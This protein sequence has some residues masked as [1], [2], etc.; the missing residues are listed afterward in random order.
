MT[1]CGSILYSF[2]GQAMVLPL[3]NKLKHPPGMVGVFGVLSVGMSLVSSVYAA[4][5]F[6]GYITY[7]ADVKGSITLNLPQQAAFTAVK[8][9]LTLVVYFGF[10]IQQ[11][12]IFDFLNFVQQMIKIWL[13]DNCHCGS[14]FGRHHSAGRSHCRNVPGFYLSRL[15]GHYDLCASLSQSNPRRWIQYA[16]EG[17]S[18]VNPEWISGLDRCLWSGGWS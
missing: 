7:G 8:V 3:E 14:Q 12:V 16:L 11:Y 17:I 5:G 13:N 10:V 4:S 2:N 6:L 15:D 9:M 18:E 1:A